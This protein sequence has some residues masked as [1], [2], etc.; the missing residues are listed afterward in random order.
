MAV[1]GAPQIFALDFETALT[2]GILLDS[3]GKLWG[4]IIAYPYNRSS[5]GD[6]PFPSGAGSS[7]TGPKRRV[8]L[9]TP[10]GGSE[11]NTAA[12]IN[13]SFGSKV[14]SEDMYNQLG[15]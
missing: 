13:L 7:I 9:S 14:S 2:H 6:K 15:L 8:L 12:G 4:P 10:L 5:Q 11:S 3:P 1:Q